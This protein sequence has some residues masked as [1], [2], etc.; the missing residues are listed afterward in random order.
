MALWLA[1]EGARSDCCESR[2]LI[3]R[4]IRTAGERYAILRTI[5]I[6]DAWYPLGT[7]HVPSVGFRH[8]IVVV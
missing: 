3:R 6:V 4:Q 1:G 5:L 2:R 8:A 7:A